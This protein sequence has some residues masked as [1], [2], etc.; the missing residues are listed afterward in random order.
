MDHEVWQQL[1][2][3]PRAQVL[4]RYEIFAGM[5]VIKGSGS[6]PDLN[7]QIDPKL[8]QTSLTLA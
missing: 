3:F 2:P 7:H 5:I 4:A 8:P 1:K 6:R